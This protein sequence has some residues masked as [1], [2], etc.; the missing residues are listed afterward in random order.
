V[1]AVVTATAVHHDRPGNVVLLRDIEGLVSLG[2]EEARR[3]VRRE[4]R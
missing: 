4:V 2:M 1:A 3:R